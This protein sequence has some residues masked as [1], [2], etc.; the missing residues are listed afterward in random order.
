MKKLFAIQAPGTSLVHQGP[1]CAVCGF[2]LY[3]PP[4]DGNP[5]RCG[6]RI[7]QS[8]RWGGEER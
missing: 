3:W 8:S 1:P 6:G 4:R 5:P 7:C 2:E